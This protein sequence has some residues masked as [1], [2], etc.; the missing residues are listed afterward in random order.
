[1]IFGPDLVYD[2]V[3]GTWRGIPSKSADRVVKRSRDSFT[4]LV[5]NT[6]RVLFSRGMKGC[7]V[8][9]VDEGTRNFFKSRME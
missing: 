3:A 4:E 7:Y 5:K 9:F 6:Y 8:Y 1:V 2:Q